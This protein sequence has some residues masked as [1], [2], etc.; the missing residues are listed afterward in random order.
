MDENFPVALETLMPIKLPVTGPHVAYRAVRD[1]YSEFPEYSFVLGFDFETNRDSGTR[2]LTAHI[3]KPKGPSVYTQLMD[4]HKKHPETP[5]QELQSKLQVEVTVLQ[6]K[7]CPALRREWD[8]LQRLQMSPPRS[9]KTEVIYLH[10]LVHEF[11]MDSMDGEM[12]AKLY[13]QEHELVKW[14]I[15]AQEAFAHCK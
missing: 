7:D 2:M 8:K 4:L 1:L 9:P 13:W 6:E 14:A 3:I 10:P 12:T 5:L 11:A 15:S